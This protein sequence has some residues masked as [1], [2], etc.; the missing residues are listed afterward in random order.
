MGVAF[1]PLYANIYYANHE[2]TQLTKEKQ[3]RIIEDFRLIN[4]KLTLWNNN[5]TISKTSAEDL[6]SFKDN[7]IINSIRWT[8]TN[9]TRTIDFLDVTLSHRRQ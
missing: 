3:P 5:T 1:A 4:D 2:E 7:I 6:Q 8:H 9:L